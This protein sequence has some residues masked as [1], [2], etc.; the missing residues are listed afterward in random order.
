MI[1]SIR[2]TIRCTLFARLQLADSFFLTGLFTQSH[3]LESFVA[4]NTVGAA[5]IVA[6]LHSYVL[7]VAELGHALAARWFMRAAYTSSLELPY[8]QTAAACWCAH[9]AQPPVTCMR[10]C[11]K[12]GMF[13]ET[14]RFKHSDIPLQAAHHASRA[15]HNAC[16]SLFQTTRHLHYSLAVRSGRSLTEEICAVLA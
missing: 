6:L 8:C 3:G 12:F 2:C 1:A 16:T 14:L 7:H 15:W 11:S 5:P 4:T 10:G 9:L 13:C